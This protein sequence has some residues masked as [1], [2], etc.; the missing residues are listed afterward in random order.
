[1]SSKRVSSKV[2]KSSLLSLAA[3]EAA[4]AVRAEADNGEE[5][6]DDDDA[7]DRFED[8]DEDDLDR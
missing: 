6:T 2:W 4:E 1:M 3:E 7:E 5:R 8:D